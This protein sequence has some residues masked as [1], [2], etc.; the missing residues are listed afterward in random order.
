MKQV[1]IVPATPDV[2][3]FENKADEVL[4]YV[5]TNGARVLDIQYQMATIANVILYSALI[6]FESDKAL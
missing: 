2:E 6:T 5:E 4:N 1:V 3:A